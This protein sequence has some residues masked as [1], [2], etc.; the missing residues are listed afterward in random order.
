MKTNGQLSK[1]LS[2][3]QTRSLRA[4]NIKKEVDIAIF[5]LC[6]TNMVWMEERGTDGKSS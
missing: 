5:S 3:G 2:D 1:G 4:M 6:Q